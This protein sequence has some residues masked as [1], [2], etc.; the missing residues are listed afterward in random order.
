MYNVHQFKINKLDLKCMG[1]QGKIGDKLPKSI[2][3]TPT[4]PNNHLYANEYPYLILK[5]F[6]ECMQHV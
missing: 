4:H 3:Y 1:N 6:F 5:E 2:R